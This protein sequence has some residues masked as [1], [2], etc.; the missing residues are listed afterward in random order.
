[1]DMDMD[2]DSAVARLVQELRWSDQT[3]RLGFRASFR[4]EYCD[5]DLLASVDTLW[6]TLEV[7]HLVPRA[8]GGDDAIDNLVFACIQCNRLKRTWDPRSTAPNGSRAP[9]IAAARGYIAEQR[10]VKER[11]LAETRRIVE[12]VGRG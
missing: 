11:E 4:C 12:A 6:W 5:R 10:T 8:A 3:A 7:D 9:L 1:M 2:M